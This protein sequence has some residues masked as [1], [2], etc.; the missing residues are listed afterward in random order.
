MGAIGLPSAA[1]GRGL[2]AARAQLQTT[3]ALDTPSISATSAAAMPDRTNET[4][5]ALGSGS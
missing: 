4:A 1:A 5:R 3:A 2:S